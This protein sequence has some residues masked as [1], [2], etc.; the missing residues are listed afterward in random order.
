MS[1]EAAAAILV[2]T[3]FTTDTSME[4]LMMSHA[5]LG[6]ADPEEIA[7][8]IVPYYA[9]MLKVMDGKQ[10]GPEKKKDEAA[11]GNSETKP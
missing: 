6:N 8:F 5:K 9:A 2:Q 11:G 10:G 3:L 4:H 1:K 7:K